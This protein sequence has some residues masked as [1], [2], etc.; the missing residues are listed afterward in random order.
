[1]SARAS[2]NDR[3][4]PA[5]AVRAAWRPKA[6]ELFSDDPA[7]ASGDRSSR[8][9]SILNKEETT[10]TSLKTLRFSLPAALI[11]FLVLMAP[12][13]AWSLNKQFYPVIFKN[14]A[15]GHFVTILSE[16]F[17][18]AFP[19]PWELINTNNF[20]WGKRTC[21]PFAGGNSGW[22]VGGGTAGAGL[23][24]G[25]N[26]PNNADS[27]MIFGPFSLADATD[28]ALHF[29]LW[30]NAENTFDTDTLCRLASVDNL[31]FYGTCS[32]GTTSGWTQTNLDLKNVNNLGDL[33]G[34]SQV[35]I[36]LIFHSNATINLPE[37][38]YLDD[39][40]LRKCVGGTCTA[41]ADPPMSLL[42]SSPVME[43]P[44]HFRRPA[45]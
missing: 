16:D 25:A 29:Q 3:V 41:P 31:N 42:G 33:R 14:Y 15:Q 43:K 2:V 5:E 8:F 37:G 11:L 45:Q 36:A 13:S 10:M 40:L 6:A 35:W 27:W 39:I 7:E 19:G 44:A 4:G 38:A 1:M 28:A 34:Q 17:E 12:L 23:A 24:C 21:R 30:L 18:G 9:C 22:A 26:Y 20:G 32:F